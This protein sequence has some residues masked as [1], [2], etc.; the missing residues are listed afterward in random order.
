MQKVGCQ[1]NRF[2]GAGYHP[3]GG[4]TAKVLFECFLHTRFLHTSQHCFHFL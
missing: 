4:L 1:K 3:H 2:G